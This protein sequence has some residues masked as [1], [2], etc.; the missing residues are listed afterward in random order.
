M[1]TRVDQYIAQFQTANRELIAL[2]TGCDE[3]GWQRLSLSEGW[4]V[5]SVAHHVAMRN[6]VV[7]GMISSMATGNTDIPN[8]SRAD[9][10]AE[11]ATH[12]ETY[13]TVGKPETLELLRENGDAFIQALQRIDDDDILNQTG[14]VF[15]GNELSVAYLIQ[16]V[17]IDHSIVHATSIR[18]TIAG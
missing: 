16:E 1:S 14:E 17:V 15:A 12:A 6:G 9:L 5:A 11:N 2:V 10:I 13:A 7:A 3:E 18:A 8:I 4:T